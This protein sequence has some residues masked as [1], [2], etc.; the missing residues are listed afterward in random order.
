MRRAK[1]KF[2]A[3]RQ[4]PRRRPRPFGR[5]TIGAVTRSSQAPR[6]GARAPLPHVI[7]N[8]A[9]T[10]DGKIAT[11]NRAVRS[12][13]SRRDHDH[14]LD[15]RATAD[16]VLCGASTAGDS[17]ITLGPG[18]EHFRR[19]RLRRGLAEFNLRVVVSGSGRLDPRADL[20]RHRFSPIIV[21]A[22]RSASRARLQR[23]RAVADEVAV[24]GGK[25]TDLRTALQ[26][27]RGRWGVSRL[28]CEGGGELNDAMFRSGLV[29]ELH[30]TVCPKIFGGRKAPTVA[31]G[32]GFARL[33]E[34]ARLQLRSHRRAGKEMF[35]IYEV[36]GEPRRSS[37]VSTQR[38][39]SQSRSDRRLK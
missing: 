11:A 18:P 21:L 34:A 19:K 33:V 38:A 23:L 2:P 27:L 30:L 12:F 16:A 31:D 7:V 5:G 1:P 10:A 35:L 24:F 29:N 26:W 14:L 39:I 8:M 36:V 15:L 13:G 25:D 22:S 37:S 20:F 17:D 4:T 28:V 3:R 9:M 32:S 6:S